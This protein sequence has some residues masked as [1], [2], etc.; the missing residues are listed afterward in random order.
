MRNTSYEHKIIVVAG[1]AS[2]MGE[3][4]VR[5]V[6]AVAGHIL[7]LDRNTSAGE[8][9]A[10][11]L[12]DTVSFTSLE[13]TDAAAVKK[14][15]QIINGKYERIDY[16][17]NFAGTFLA[18]EI[19]DTPLSDWNAIFKSNIEPI[20]NGTTAIYEIMQKNGFG[21]IIN[22]A[23]SAGLFPVPI[24]NIYGATKSAIVSLTLGL[25]MEAKT[26]GIK[27]SVVCPTIVETPLYDTALYAGLNKKKALSY[28][29]NRAHVQQPQQAAK[30]IL[31]KVAK[32]RTIIHT[33]R[34]TQ[35]GWAVFRLSPALYMYFAK[36]YI[37]LYRRTFR[38]KGI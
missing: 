13:M 34:S 10:N 6:S 17:F 30:Q 24:M 35:V 38:K 37:T 8:A 20:I 9:L 23:S 26:F 5:Q 19:R 29:K 4:L 21:H 25:R 16:F 33:S 3:H 2:G 15:L 22:V 28:L 18:G 12:G 1:G 36:K 14:V 11:E 32:N 27:A 7:I 31:K